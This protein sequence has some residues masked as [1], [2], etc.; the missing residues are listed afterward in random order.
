MSSR[1]GWM[2]VTISSVY[3]TFFSF[4]TNFSFFW[5]DCAGRTCRR[6]RKEEKEGERER[7]K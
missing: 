7:E 2:G 5:W 6:E 4:I 1:L 3:P